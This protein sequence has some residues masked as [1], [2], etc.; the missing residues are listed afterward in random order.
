MADS[1]YGYDNRLRLPNKAKK[2][3]N[4]CGLCNCILRAALSAGMSSRSSDS[5][6]A[7]RGRARRIPDEREIIPAV[8]DGSV[9][10][11]SGAAIA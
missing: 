9:A 2:S 4:L 11:K 7:Y 6:L 3:V 10:I 5:V 1:P 8:S